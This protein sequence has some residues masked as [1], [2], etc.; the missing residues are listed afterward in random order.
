MEDEADRPSAPSDDPADRA[1]AVAAAEVDAESEAAAEAFD[2]LGPDRDVAPLIGLPVIE[3]RSANPATC[4]F[5]RSVDEADVLGPPIETPDPRNRCAAFGA[6]RPQSTR[7]QQ[8]VCLANAHVNCPRYLRGSLVVAEPVRRAAVQRGPS[9]AVI[10]ASLVLVAAIAASFGFVLV[11]GGLAMP[12]RSIEP[13]QVAVVSIE[14]SASAPTSPSPLPTASPSPDPTPAPTD[15]PTPSPSPVA[16][17]AP[18]PSPAPPSPTPRA[19]SDRYL[20]LTAC[21]DAPDCWIYPIRPGDNLVSIA[22]YFGVPLETVYEMNPETRTSGIRP[23]QELRLPP[24][25]R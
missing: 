10:A 13:S 23:G 14:P 20:L 24:P 12:V 25:T 4:P 17:P 16:T 2:D 21:P 3:G 1:D 7:Q 11:R 8:L 18:T 15:A 6:A 5:F 19:T 9:T 22:N